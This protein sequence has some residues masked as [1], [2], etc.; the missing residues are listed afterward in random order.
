M[1]R[2]VM[3]LDQGTTSSRALLFDEAGRVAALSQREFPQHFR[4]P[5]WVEHDA[6][7]IWESQLAAAREALS[8]AGARACDIAAIG[9]KYGGY[10]AQQL[11]QMARLKKAEMPR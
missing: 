5:G 2:Y 9:I 10:L 7:E 11:Q 1:S 3:A 4:Q 8:A 6:E